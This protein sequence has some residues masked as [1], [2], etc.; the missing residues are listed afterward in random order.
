MS[1]LP[2]P[3][4]AYADGLLILVAV[5]CIGWIVAELYIRGVI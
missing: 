2:N 1:D 4:R 5:G 3:G